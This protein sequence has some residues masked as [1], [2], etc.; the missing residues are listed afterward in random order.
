MSAARHLAIAAEPTAAKSPVTANPCHAEDQFI[1]SLMW[2]GCHH[3]LALIELVPA[4]AIWQPIARWAYELVATT[5]ANGHDP[6]PV[7]VKAVGRHRRAHDAIAAD[8]PPTARQQQHLAHYLFEAYSQAPNPEAAD[9]YAREV[10]DDAYRRAFDTF[11]IRMQEL[12][13]SGADRGDLT[14]QFAA[15]RDQLASLWRLA[16]AAAQPERNR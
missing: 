6:T 13:A 15:I 12:A 7:A 11:G 8:R 3:A 2:L 16:E 5:V 1:G 10:L 14:D 9:T 4:T